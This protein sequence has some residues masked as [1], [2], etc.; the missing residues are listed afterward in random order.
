MGIE[1]AGIAP[2]GSGGATSVEATQSTYDV[3]D[4]PSRRESEFTHLANVHV[5]ALR[6]QLR[7][8]VIK[9]PKVN[10]MGSS[11]FFTVVIWLDH[12]SIGAIIVGCPQAQRLPCHQIRA[13]RVDTGIQNCQLIAIERLA[14]VRI[15]RLSTH[16]ETCCAAEIPSQISPA[17]TVYVRVH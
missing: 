17:L 15:M 9:N 7:V 10:L 2:E 1:V 13:I 11:H 8:V 16:V 5:V 6:I 4:F 14:D 3:S 12:I